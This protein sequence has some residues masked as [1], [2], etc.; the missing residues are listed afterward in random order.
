MRFPFGYHHSNTDCMNSTVV[1]LSVLTLGLIFS[2]EIS[3]CLNDKIVEFVGLRP[4]M[5]SIKT[6]S[7]SKKT[8]KGIK[9]SVINQ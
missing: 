2:E 1:M 7:D 4:K 9:K 5:Y 8:A 3:E 6:E